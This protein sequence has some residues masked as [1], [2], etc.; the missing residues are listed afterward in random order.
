VLDLCGA[1]GGKSTLLASLLDDSSLLISNEVIRSRATILEENVV[2]WGYTNNWVT[3]NDPKDIGRLDGYF[4]VIVVDAPCSGSG[5]FRKDD[6][7]LRDWTEA[8][9]HLCSQRQQRIIAD[10]WPSLKEDGIFVYATCS[11]SHEEDEDMLDWISDEF[12]VQPLSADF[13]PEWG[14]IITES[15]QRL[16][17]YRFFPDKLKGEGFFIAAVQKKERPGS[18][19]S[20]KYKTLSNSKAKAQSAYLLS[21]DDLMVVPASKESFHAI[22]PEHEA[23]WHLLQKFLYFRKTGLALG[24]PA[25]KEWIPAHDI[26]LSIDRSAS[27]KTVEVSANQALRFLRKDEIEL[28]VNEKGWLLISYNGLGLGWVKCLGNRSN[29]YLPKHWRIRMEIE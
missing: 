16:T 14:I 20:P 29:N 8:N 10:I 25:A 3:S 19:R 21:R 22:L 13:P 24:T 2:R 12:S 11:Y 27:I 9:V 17:G 15:K 1:P 28:P 6:H 23:D 26:A 18:I 5:L 4:D 7:A